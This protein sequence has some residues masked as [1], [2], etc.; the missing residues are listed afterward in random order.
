VVCVPPGWALTASTDLPEVNPDDL[1]SFLELRAERE[2]SIP[3]SDLRIAF[4]AYSLPGGNKRATLAA[5]QSKRIEAVGKML[6]AAGCRAVSISLALDK[7]F[8]DSQP[9][10]HFLANGT[11]T[12]V[13]I[14]AEGGVASLRSLAGPEA[15]GETAF[16]AETF[17][18]EIRVTLGRLP[19]E[20]RQQ[21]RQA[22]FTGTTASAQRLCL[23][24]RE[25][26]QR[27]GIGSAEFVPAQTAGGESSEPV[28]AATDSAQSF[29]RK[30]PVAFEFVVPE[31]QKWQVALQR[32]DNHRHR[33]IALAVAGAVV[34]PLLLFFI[35]S[36]MENHY[37]SQWDAMKKNVA[38]LDALQQ[39]IHNYRPWFE[40]SPQGLQAIDELVAAFPDQGDVWAK[41]VHIGDD[42]KI[43]CTG[44]ARNEA[45]LTAL[46]D[47]LGKRKNV[48][49]LR[50]G[51]LLGDKPLQFSFT[52][53]WEHSHE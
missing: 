50:R 35:R 10:L 11:H 34:L 42:G 9:A 53:K 52:Y 23:L 7:C 17:C 1:R 14:T 22:R 25:P 5:V 16:D 49:E 4:S 43:T 28:G 36:Q 51:Q 12:D 38:E 45:A 39:K 40:P 18:R 2:F 8:S 19:E 20:L 30:Q 37:A 48:S 26:L 13:V 21:V 29:L 41:S 24:T 33:W 6:E 46:L 44:F 32:F 31:V 27:L 15:S 3:V 47:R